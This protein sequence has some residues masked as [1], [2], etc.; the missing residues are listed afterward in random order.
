MINITL[1][2]QFIHYIMYNFFSKF[3]QL[4]CYHKF[5]QCYKNMN[6]VNR[7]CRNIDN[8]PNGNK[9][10][11]INWLNCRKHGKEIGW[12]EN[13]N[14]WVEIDWQNDQRHGKEIWWYENGCI[15]REINWR[16]DQR[17]GKEIH[18]DENGNKF[19]EKDWEY[20]K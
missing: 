16:N 4:R 7:Y 6:L 2:T 12:C 10:H 1:K 13:G 18:W 15:W 3:L 14:K 11:E 20:N 5:N 17:H 9:R 8:Y 19:Y